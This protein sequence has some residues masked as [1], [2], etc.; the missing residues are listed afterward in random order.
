ML[1][2]ISA[3][4]EGFG[5]G[6]DMA[7]LLQKTEYR[8][9]SNRQSLLEKNSEYFVVNLIICLGKTGRGDANGEAGRERGRVI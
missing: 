3:P 9:D 5:A 1:L 8:E 2:L 4:S 6:T 7:A